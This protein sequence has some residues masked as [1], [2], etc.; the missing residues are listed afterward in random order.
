MR[1]DLD[2]NKDAAGQPNWGLGR[3]CEIAAASASV[4][5]LGTGVIEANLVPFQLRSRCS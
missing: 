2:G 1:S 5:S 4:Q 3:A